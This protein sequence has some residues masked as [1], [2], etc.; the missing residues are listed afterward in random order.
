MNTQKMIGLGL[1][2]MG[3]IVELIVVSFSA[4][5]LKELFPVSM[6]VLGV[7]VIVIAA[8]VVETSKLALAGTLAFNKA[9]GIHMK[10]SARIT[11]NVLTVLMIAVTFAGTWSYFKTTNNTHYIEIDN[12]V[13]TISKITLEGEA[14][15]T[16]LSS[17]NI[18]AETLD[19]Q[20]LSADDRLDSKL[21]PFISKIDGLNL[22]LDEAYTARDEATDVAGKSIDSSITEIRGNMASVR[23]LIDTERKR[24]LHFIVKAQ[25]GVAGIE[26]QI[27]KA[28]VTLQEAQGVGSLT[29]PAPIKADIQRLI[30]RLTKANDKLEE[31]NYGKDDA[32]LE[33]TMDLN[34]EISTNTSDIRKLTTKK[35]NLAEEAASQNARIER[36][37]KSIAKVEANME[38]KS[39]Q[40]E[41][42]VFAL[43]S[44]NRDRIAD[45][46]QTIRDGNTTLNDNANQ[47]ASLEVLKAT[48]LSQVGAAKSIA[49]SFGMDGRSAGSLLAALYSLPLVLFGYFMVTFGIK[50]AYSKETEVAPVTPA[51]V[52]PAPVCCSCC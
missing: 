30:K 48:T 14:L 24:V 37:I 36:I 52:A 34:A 10:T 46:Q 51:P 15:V 32:I 12:A 50:T 1:L 5:G 49:D 22:Q 33:A 39:S 45:I 4:S 2:V 11:M 41:D 18:E 26:S 6:A 7:S 44:S 25:S 19:T 20:I 13:L 21:A 16:K 29:D 3:L 27:E 8:Y 17:L 35:N 43:V 31:L 40:I 28:N 42:E 9:K 47:I 38:A 23:K